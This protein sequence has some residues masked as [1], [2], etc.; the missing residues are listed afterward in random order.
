MPRSGPT[1]V[2]NEPIPHER[3]LAIPHERGLALLQRYLRSR[4]DKP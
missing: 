4:K 2:G 1:E 3:G